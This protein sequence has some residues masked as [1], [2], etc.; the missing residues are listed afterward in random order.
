MILKKPL[1]NRE[2]R[3]QIRE[4]HPK[5]LQGTDTYDSRLKP[6][7][8]RLVDLGY[9]SGETMM[10]DTPEILQALGVWDAD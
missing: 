2:L 6:L 9:V 3:E 4:I 10:V 8:D 7:L 1:R 5:P